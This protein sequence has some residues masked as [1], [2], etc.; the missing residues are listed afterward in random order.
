[1]KEEKRVVSCVFCEDVGAAGEV[2]FEDASVWVIVHPDW[3]PAGHLMVVAK[4]HVENVSDL[5]E[6]QWLQIASV[7]HRAEKAVLQATG[8]QRAMILKLG[9]VTAH[10]H[11]HIYPVAATALRDE[12]FAAFDGKRGVARDEN[13]VRNLRALLTPAPH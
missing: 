1:M 9:I 5:A 4:T 3:S 2:V 8:A 13:L 12:V 7:W 10:L 11:V 6:E